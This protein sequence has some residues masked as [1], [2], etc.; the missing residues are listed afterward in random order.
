MYSDFISDIFL[1]MIKANLHFS[2]NS[3]Q[4]NSSFT[5]ACSALTCRYSYNENDESYVS[6]SSIIRIITSDLGESKVQL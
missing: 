2:G 5:L 4:F 6:S 1:R 3:Y